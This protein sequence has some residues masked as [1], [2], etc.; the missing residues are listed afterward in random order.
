MSAIRD[1]KCPTVR[2]AWVS[3]G[4]RSICGLNSVTWQR[5]ARHT[6]AFCPDDFLLMF[7]ASRHAGRMF[8]AMGSPITAGNI[9]ASNT[10]PGVGELCRHFYMLSWGI[11]E[12]R[13]PRIAVMS[14]PLA[15]VFL[16]VIILGLGNPLAAG[17]DSRAS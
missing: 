5:V 1:A 9:I 11:A 2:R 7:M 6:R 10:L 13:L 3:Y 8:F 17:D 16:P 14:Q 15:F 4:G 12:H